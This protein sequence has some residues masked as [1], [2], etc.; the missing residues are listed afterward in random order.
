MLETSCWGLRFALCLELRVERVGFLIR[1]FFTAGGDAHDKSV[2][3]H[4]RTRA[5]LHEVNEKVSS[6]SFQVSFHLEWR[7]LKL[8]PWNFLKGS[9]TCKTDCWLLSNGLNYFFYYYGVGSSSLAACSSGVSTAGSSSLA[10]YSRRV[11]ASTLTLAALFVVAAAHC[12]QRNSSDQKNF[13]HDFN[14]LKGLCFRVISKNAAK[15]AHFLH[16]SKKNS[17]FAKHF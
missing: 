16:I 3:Q 11:A 2:C 8:E 17:I 10:A 9:C 12:A 14:A 1:S 13:F 15:L 5:F 6:F 7:N 4:L